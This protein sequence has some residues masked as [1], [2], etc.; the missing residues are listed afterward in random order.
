VTLLLSSFPCARAKEKWEVNG[1]HPKMR[2]FAHSC[3]LVA[4]ALA[5]ALAGSARADAGLPLPSGVPPITMLLCTMIRNESNYLIEWIEFHKM[6]GFD[7]VRIYDNT[8]TSDKQ[9]H[10]KETLSKVYP[11]LAAANIS[12]VDGW[13]SGQASAFMNCSHYGD[14]EKFD[15]VAIHDLDE[16]WFSPLHFTVKDYAWYVMNNFPNT[17]MVHVHQFRYGPKGQVR[18]VEL[19]SLLI[20]EELWRAPSNILGEAVINEAI[21][22]GPLLDVCNDCSDKNIK[23][24]DHKRTL[25]ICDKWKY[26][27]SRDCGHDSFEQKTFFRTGHKCI[28]WIHYTVPGTCQGE[29]MWADPYHLRGNHYYLRSIEEGLEKALYWGKSKS[30]AT[31]RGTSTIKSGATQFFESI[32]DGSILQWVPELKERIR[33]ATGEAFADYNVGGLGI[34][35]ANV[36]KSG[37][38]VNDNRKALEERID[39]RMRGN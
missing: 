17:T 14:Q 28:G 35:K 6:Q 38:S 34:L 15:W 21:V 33:A 27:I 36:E 9:P 13:P 23:G 22:K 4:A 20:E 29:Q 32:Y 16:F 5:T 24:V 18:P 2:A 31:M 37:K 10:I 30:A 12:I 3:C 11:D 25:E 1:K 8:H 19:P 26:K 7:A 39:R